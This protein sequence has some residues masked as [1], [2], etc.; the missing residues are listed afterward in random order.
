MLTGAGIRI[1]GFRKFVGVKKMMINV[2]SKNIQSLYRIV[3]LFCGLTP[4]ILSVWLVARYGVNVIYWD[5]WIIA[6]LLEKLTAGELTA[7]DLFEAHNQHRQFFPRLIVV[8]LTWVTKNYSSI[9]LLYIGQMSLFMGLWAILA[10]AR[11]QFRLTHSALLLWFLPIPFLLFNWR[12]W[13]NL[14][15]SFQLAYLLPLSCTFVSLHALQHAQDH[16]LTLKNSRHL[17]SA[18]LFATI[19]TYS[20]MTGIFVWVA[21]ACQIAVQNM[22]RTRLKI[23]TFWIVMGAAEWIG[24]FYGLPETGDVF[25]SIAKPLAIGHYFLTLL[26]S[27][28]YSRQYAIW[29]GVILLG[30]FVFVLLR[31]GIKL[32]PEQAFWLAIAIYSACVLTSIA[33]G[34]SQI[35]IESAH[36]SRYAT[37]TIPWIVAVYGL[38]ITLLNRRSGTSPSKLDVGLFGVLL[39]LIVIGLT[40]AYTKGWRDSQQTH[41]F[42]EHAAMTIVAYESASD[43]ELMRVYPAPAYI[44]QHAPFLRAHGYNMFHPADLRARYLVK[45]TIDFRQPSSGRLLYTGWSHGEHWGRW[46]IAREALLFLMLPERRAYAMTLT[47]Q[48]PPLIEKEQMVTISLNATGLTQIV[49]PQGQMTQITTEIP[50]T[51][52]TGQ[53]EI[54]KFQSYYALSPARQGISAD[55]R[56][57]AVGLESIQIR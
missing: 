7:T 26:G 36:W 20:T 57:L 8:V 4:I 44:R 25:D 43:E 19:A 21:G 31:G 22:S 37:Y 2:R 29:Y 13:E 1:S 24:Y 41:A 11:R 30:L 51:A 14:L 23:L 53:I 5:E 17:L 52:L 50:E 9:A 15:W 46:A 35:G 55:N 56:T 16:P 48:A 32:L 10:Q 49:L 54:L 33:I 18:I 47:M 34:R 45:D 12:Q 40:M 42:Y 6:P 38:F 27:L 3:L 28:A 39:S